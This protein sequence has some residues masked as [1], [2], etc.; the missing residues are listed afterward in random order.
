MKPGPYPLR[1][2]KTAGAPAQGARPRIL[3]TGFGPFPE[4]PFNA[5]AALVETL[6]EASLPPR[7]SAEIHAAVLPT[8]WRQ[9]PALMRALHKDFRPHA[10]LHFGVSSRARHLQIETRAF[11]LR[12][13]ARDCSGRLPGGYY[14]NPA[15]PPVLG[16]TLPVK[17]LLH[18]LRLAGI[19]A[20]LSRNAGR[21][22][23]NATLYVSL[24]HA[25]PARGSLIGFVHI[26]ALTPAHLAGSAMPPPGLGFSEVRKGAGVILH[27]LAHFLRTMPRAG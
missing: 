6:A 5:S 16:A 10:V 18:R 3:V 20:S 1:R 25:M 4:M 24:L 8:D 15:G 26:P 14:V 13:A 22:L 2:S 7:P 23:C 27:T 19:P 11:N 17:L 21:Y 12:H 9:A